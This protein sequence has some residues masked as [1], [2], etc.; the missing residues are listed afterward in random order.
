MEQ[1][2]VI[3]LV[4]I[5]SA[6]AY[7]A[8]ARNAITRPMRQAVRTLVECVGTFALFLGFNLAAGVAIVFLIRGLT[9]HFIALYELQSLFLVLL[10]AAQGLVFQLWW[11]RDF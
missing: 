11:R 5:T 8:T 9:S 4:A 10:S 7:F 1:T 6:I 3:L 2:F